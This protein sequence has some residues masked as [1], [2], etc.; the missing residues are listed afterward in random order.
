[1]LLSFGSFFA[2]GFQKYAM[3]ESAK[4]L[5]IHISCIHSDLMSLAVMKPY[6]SFQSRGGAVKMGVQ[7]TENIQKINEF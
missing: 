4:D 3:R 6:L 5:T 2:H 7:K 1:V